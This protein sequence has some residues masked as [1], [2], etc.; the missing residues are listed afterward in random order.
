M[1]RLI[2]LAFM[3]F[4]FES[5]AQNLPGEMY[6]S[7]DGK[8]LFTGGNTPEGMYDKNVIRKVYLDFTQSDYWEQLE[9][10]YESETE[11]P[12]SMTIDGIVYDSVGVR[13]RGNTS[14]TMIADSP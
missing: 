4:T 3:I 5:Y 12:A 13:F 1:Q 11:I 9:D 6:Y 2:L 7:M 10:N 8:T 14:Y